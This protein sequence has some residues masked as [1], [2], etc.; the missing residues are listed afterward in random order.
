MA[1]LDLIPD[2]SLVSVVESLALAHPLTLAG[3]LAACSNPLPVADAV[4]Q[5]PTADAN[6]FLVGCWN[7][8]WEVAVVH[9]VAV[10]RLRRLLHADVQVAQAENSCQAAV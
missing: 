2:H 4:V 10:L 5:V 3:R 6:S 1:A 9:A 8:S 7:D